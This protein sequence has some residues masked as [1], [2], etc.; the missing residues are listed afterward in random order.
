[1]HVRQPVDSSAV[2]TRS[3]FKIRFIRAAYRVHRW[4]TSL[5]AFTAEGLQ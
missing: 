1:M 3:D 5:L 2:A 4:G